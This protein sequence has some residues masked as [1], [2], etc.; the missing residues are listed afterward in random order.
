MY[1]SY[2]LAESGIKDIREQQ[3]QNTGRI[4]EENRLRKT[5]PAIET[6]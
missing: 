1:L 4:K 5:E 6:H 2:L 3:G